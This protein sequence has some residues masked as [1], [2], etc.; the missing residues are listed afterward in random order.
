MLSK[1]AFVI[2]EG[3]NLYLKKSLDFKNEELIPFKYLI[4]T[5]EDRDKLPTKVDIIELNDVLIIQI[6]ENLIYI[7]QNNFLIQ[8]E[9][10]FSANNL[11]RINIIPKVTFISITENLLKKLYQ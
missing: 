6:Y 7:P 3:L 9:N 8:F 11:I 4:F 2:K 5:T 1:L 10:L